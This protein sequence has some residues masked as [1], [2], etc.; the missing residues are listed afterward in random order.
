LSAD[1]RMDFVQTINAKLENPNWTQIREWFAER[2]ELAKAQLGQET[3]LIDAVIAVRSG[4]VRF[5]GQGF[6]TEVSMS[7]DMLRKGDAAAFAKAFHARYE[8]LYGVAQ[9]HVPG[10]L[11]NIRLTIIGRRK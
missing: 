2:E 11:V 8:Q 4:D 7:D 1:F 10:E 9:A 3:D 6:N 5:E